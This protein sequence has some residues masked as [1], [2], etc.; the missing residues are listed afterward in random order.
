MAYAAHARDPTPSQRGPPMQ[1]YTS[2]RRGR[3][4][5]ETSGAQEASLPLRLLGGGW[6]AA[7]AGHALPPAAAVGEGPAD[8]LGG[9][10]QRARVR[11]GSAERAG[12]ARAARGCPDGACPRAPSGPRAPQAAAGSPT[13]R[14]VDADLADGPAPR[15]GST[16][17]RADRAEAHRAE[18]GR[19]GR[20]R[21]R[22]RGRAPVGELD[23]RHRHA[24]GGGPAAPRRDAE[25]P[26][27]SG[28]RRRA[29]HQHHVAERARRPASAAVRT[30]ADEASPPRAAD[31]DFSANSLRTMLPAHLRA[32][33]RQHSLC[34]GKGALRLPRSPFSRLCTGTEYM[35]ECILAHRLKMRVY[36]CQCFVRRNKPHAWLITGIQPNNFTVNQNG[37]SLIPKR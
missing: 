12:V 5:D 4:S 25:R 27:S 36:M 32:L 26:R 7:P 16:A 14:I 34:Q 8:S 3:E 20:G 18:M 30:H 19:D 17:Q 22:G 21:G 15:R 24:A 6:Q 33:C 28:P 13:A 2:F 29:A 11:A 1:S 37:L 35:C 9:G 10:G 31:F 23:A